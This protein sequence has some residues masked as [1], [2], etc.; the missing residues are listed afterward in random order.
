MLSAG[1]RRAAVETPAVRIE[2]STRVLGG[3]TIWRDLSLE[4]GA[5]E[6]LT[7]IGPNGAGKTS[8]LKVLLGLLPAS[9]DVDVLGRPPGR[10][11]P[12]IGYVPQQK[13]IDPDLPL[14][15]RD[16]VRMGLDGARWGPGLGSRRVEGRVAE[17]LSWVGAAPFADAPVGRLSGGE[18]QRLRIA[19]ALI[20]DPA[21]LLLDEPLLSLDLHNQREICAL[22]A[23][24]QR[25]SGGTVI[26][27]TH[28]VNPV[29]NMTNRVMAV[30]GGRWAAG[31]PDEIL[32]T[33]A[34][35][36]LYGSPVEVVRLG[37]RVA[38]LAETGDPFGSHHDLTAP[39][40]KV[41]AGR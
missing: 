34:M 15:G 3:R 4:I 37:G 40:G 2:R 28:D 9:G 10:G 22:I 27:V 14:R 1:S 6:F 29:L 5:G 25:E 13:A 31:R 11:N 16:L 32:T 41:Q 33:K 19:Q 39:P 17:A 30:V 7:I 36:S 35:S 20:G 38:V 8:L 21:L 18:Q 23:G 24:W 26:F 12:R